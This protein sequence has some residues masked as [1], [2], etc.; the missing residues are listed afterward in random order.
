M[1]GSKCYFPS[2]RFHKSSSSEMTLNFSDRH[3][4]EISLLARLQLEGIDY[5]ICNGSEIIKMLIF[6]SQSEAGFQINS[7]RTVLN[8]GITCS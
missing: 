6:I 7:R 2:L 5:I 8:F 1:T 3:R 4:R